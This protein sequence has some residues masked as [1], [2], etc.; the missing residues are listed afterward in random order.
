MISRIYERVCY[1]PNTTLFISSYL[2]GYK[3]IIK[4]FLLFFPLL[5]SH[6]SPHLVS[7]T[8]VELVSLKSVFFASSVKCVLVVFIYNCAHLCQNLLKNSSFKVLR[9][10]YKQKISK[11]RKASANIR[12]YDK[13][14]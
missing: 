1:T 3:Y 9:S 7:L 10:F 5:F 4:V 2:N 14:D 12:P 6:S 13:G 11:T 8:R